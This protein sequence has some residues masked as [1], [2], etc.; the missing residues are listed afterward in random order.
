MWTLKSFLWCKCLL[1]WFL[2]FVKEFL[3]FEK[4]ILQNFQQNWHR[5]LVD[6]LVDEVIATFKKLSH[7]H[8]IVWPNDNSSP[9]SLFLWPKLKWKKN[10]DVW[11]ITFWFITFSVGCN[12]LQL[13]FDN[14]T[15]DFIL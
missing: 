2:N 5:P 8:P 12:H 9:H 4:S 10:D 11:F 15:C 3:N 14:L 13:I 7:Q 1:V 6:C